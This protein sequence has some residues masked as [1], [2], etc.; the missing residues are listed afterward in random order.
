M[1]ETDT[2]PSRCCFWLRNPSTWARPQVSEDSCFNPA[3]RSGTFKLFLAMFSFLSSNH[4]PY[5]LLNPKQS[6]NLGKGGQMGN[7]DKVPPSCPP[8]QPMEQ[9]GQSLPFP[10]GQP[11][12]AWP[13]A[14]PADWRVGGGSHLFFWGISFFLPPP[15]LQP[16]MSHPWCGRADPQ[17]G[18]PSSAQH[19]KFL[20]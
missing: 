20:W 6:V 19:K 5:P 3:P 7:E 2:F 8:L 14:K 11:C 1:P 18:W 12:P 4:C 9:Q 10:Q 17:R 15:A 13:R 16:S